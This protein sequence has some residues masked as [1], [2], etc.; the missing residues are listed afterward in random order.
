MFSKEEYI[1]EQAKKLNIDM[2]GFTSCKPLISMESFLEDRIK[3]DKFTEFEE[4]DI[5]KRIDPKYQLSTCKSIIT[6]ALSY[7]I[8]LKDEDKE[9]INNIK[10]KGKLSKTSWGIDYHHI[11]RDSMENLVSKVKEKY[12]FDYK[13]FVDTGPLIDRE[14]AFKSGIGYYGK[15]CSIINDDYGSFIFIGYILTSLDLQESNIKIE[16]KCNDCDLCI[17]ACPTNALEKEYIINPKRCISYLTQTKND[18]DESLRIKMNNSLY[19]CDICQLVCPKNKGVKKTKNN[20]FYPKETLGYIDIEKIFNISNKEFKRQ[21]GSMSG[22]WRGK[23]IFVRNAIIALANENKYKDEALNLLKKEKYKK[24]QKY[25]DYI[26]WAIER[27][28]TKV[29]K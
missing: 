3:K 6:I 12:D 8:D 4:V 28:N 23:S 16:N 10:L 19:G 29:M 21:Y 18:I 7:N 2:I 9:K 15:N 26:D 22:S 1:I 13:I 27:I 17:R 25:E 5:S 11:L 14:I 24:N 20:L